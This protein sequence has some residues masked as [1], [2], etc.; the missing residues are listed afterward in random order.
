MSYQLIHEILASKNTLSTAQDIM[1]FMSNIEYGYVSNT[2]KRIQKIE[3]TQF[4]NEYRLQTPQQVL[5]SK[6]GVCWDQTELER[7]IF[8][9]YI[10]IPFKIYYLEALNKYQQ[11]HTTLAFQENNKWYW[12]EHSWY[13]KRGIHEY[14]TEQSFL[15]DLI[16]EHYKY[17][18]KDRK[19]VV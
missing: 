19:S 17:C 4:Y 18:E 6:L 11:T 5:T 10:K 13:D 9:K 14:K 15:K 16:N 3:G 7:F 8:S 1:S 2:G 12:F